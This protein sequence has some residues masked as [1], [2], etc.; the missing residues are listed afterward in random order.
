MAIRNANNFVVINT[1]I[2]SLLS[3]Y[4]NEQKSI[5]AWQNKA[6]KKF[7]HLLASNKFTPSWFPMLSPW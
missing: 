6:K 1:T 5:K 2:P 4:A 3:S 7:S